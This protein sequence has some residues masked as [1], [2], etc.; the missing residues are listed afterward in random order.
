MSESQ[1]VEATTTDLLDIA[2]RREESRWQIAVWPG[3]VHVL[4]S[5]AAVVGT[6]TATVLWQP[7]TRIRITEYGLVIET[8]T[9]VYRPMPGDRTFVIREAQ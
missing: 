8:T 2:V 9:A 4:A 3:P 7:L 5:D 1:I 6:T